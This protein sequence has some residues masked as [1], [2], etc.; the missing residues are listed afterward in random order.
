M[1]LFFF[2]ILYNH[3][4][5]G[6][7]QI[8]WNFLYGFPIK[9]IHFRQRVWWQAWSNQGN[10]VGNERMELIKINVCR[11]HQQNDFIYLL[12]AKYSSEMVGTC[13]INWSSETLQSF[14]IYFFEATPLKQ[15]TLD[16]DDAN[17]NF[18]PEFYNNFLGSRPQGCVKTV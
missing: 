9:L 13:F 11:N 10:G 18:F 17:L 7:M 2:K 12:G 4:I 1:V 15:K 3:M 8:I 14:N 16:F 5:F 6:C